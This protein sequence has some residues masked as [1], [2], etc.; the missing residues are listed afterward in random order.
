MSEDLSVRFD[1]SVSGD[2]GENWDYSIRISKYEGDSEMVLIIEEAESGQ[3]S[4]SFPLKALK[5]AI[6]RFEKLV[7]S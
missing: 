7:K 5:K 4:I 3:E 2:D 1:E 6:N